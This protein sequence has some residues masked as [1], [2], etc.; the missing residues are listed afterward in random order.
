MLSFMKEGCYQDQKKEDCLLKQNT[1]LQELRERFADK[2]CKTS[3][4]T[5]E[6][7][8]YT[9]VS[10]YTGEKDMDA[11]IRKLAAQ[12]AYEALKVSEKSN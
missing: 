8:A 7:I 10:H 12:Q 3:V 2:P 9:V 1:T 11:V 6:G 5:V 4:Y